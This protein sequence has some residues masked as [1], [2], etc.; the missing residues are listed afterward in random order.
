MI[1]AGIARRSR[2]RRTTPAPSDR[3]TVLLLHPSAGLYGADRALLSLVERLDPTAF[4]SVVALP[5]DGPLVARLE[6]AGA[7]VE[8]APLGVGAQASASA[9]GAARL[10]LELPRAV[11]AVRAL[12]RRHRV[13]LV[14]TNT[15][16]VLGGALAARTLDAP[17]LWHLHEIP[18][19]PA[20]VARAWPPLVARLADLAVANSRATADAF[21]AG[22]PALAPRTR[23]VP[24]GVESVPAE[25]VERRRG[26]ARA[27]LG[28]AEGELLVLLPG[29][30]NA[31][32][33]QPLLLEAAA[34]LRGRLP[35]ARYLLAGDAPP[36]QARFERALDS[37]IDRL[38]V[39]DLVRRVPFREDPTD[40][41]AAAD[42]VAVPS[43]RPEPFGLV[44]A[45][46]MAHGR[47][48]V[49]AAHGGLVELVEDGRTGRL[50][51]PGDAGALADALAHVLAD[52]ERAR[53]LGAAGRAR[54][55]ERFTVERYAA[56]LA[57]T[58]RELARAARG[59]KP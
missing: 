52:D 40:L 48:V 53:A 41:Y 59:G 31:W 15:M 35:R 24:N 19:H 54:Q 3:L 46:A 26:P 45:E 47:P 49:A 10:S 23:V 43:T 42:V 38:G 2:A 4:R 27:A 6:R 58:Y 36:G 28:L 17:H 32:K 20:W 9:R 5:C 1:P 13:D 39:G 30:V 37:G 18:T 12:A 7:T 11:A 44:A 29:R 22:A 14:H 8:R 55:R 25:L 51:T 33:G 34:R 16:V 21:V 56:S 57:A 50:F